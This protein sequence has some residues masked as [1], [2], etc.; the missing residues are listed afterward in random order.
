MSDDY[1][2]HDEVMAWLRE[3]VGNFYDAGIKTHS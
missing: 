2:V 1:E 3:Q